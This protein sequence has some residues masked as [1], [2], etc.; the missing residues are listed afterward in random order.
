MDITNA[1]AGGF[2]DNPAV[3]LHPIEVSQVALGA[4]RNN[5]L[6]MGFGAA[7]SER[8]NDLLSG[9]PLKGGIYRRF[10]RDR[11]TVDREQGITFADVETR[12][13]EGRL[14]TSRPVW[15]P[16]D[17]FDYPRTGRL[18]QRPV[19]TEETDV[20]RLARRRRSP[21]RM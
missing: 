4:D 3:V 15:H 7:P 2:V 5:D 17:L 12:T 14:N 13:G 9:Q 21:V 6:V 10:A 8:E 18:V 19:R 16:V 1:T 11:L 20:N